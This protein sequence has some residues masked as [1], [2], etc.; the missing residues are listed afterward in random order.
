[1]LLSFISFRLIDNQR[2]GQVFILQCMK[3]GSGHTE[4]T[5]RTRYEKG[6]SEGIDNKK[7]PKYFYLEAL[8]KRRLPTLPQYAV[9]SA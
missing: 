7:A 5:V 2:N 3:D 6:F 1:M 9:P 4:Q 8:L